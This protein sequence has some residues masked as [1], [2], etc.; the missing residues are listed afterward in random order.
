MCLIDTV[1]LRKDLFIL[2]ILYLVFF[3][4]KFRK[5]FFVFL[6]SRHEYRVRIC[7]L[8]FQRITETTLN[9]KHNPGE[10]LRMNCLVYLVIASLFILATNLEFVL[11]F[12]RHSFNRSKFFCFKLRNH[13]KWNFINTMTSMVQFEP[14]QFHLLPFRLW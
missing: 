9:T 12:W 4:L 6:C 3:F 8:E 5:L 2:P 7:C 1:Y 11:L 14:P 13:R 10:S